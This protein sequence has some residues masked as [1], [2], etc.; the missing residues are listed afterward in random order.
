MEKEFG[1]SGNAV[2]SGRCVPTEPVEEILGLWVRD[3]SVSLLFPFFKLIY[4]F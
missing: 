4:L 2:P 3:F 1:G